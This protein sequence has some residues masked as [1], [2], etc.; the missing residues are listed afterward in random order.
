[1][2]THGQ[3][4]CCE[5]KFADLIEIK[6][7]I[8]PEMYCW[9]NAYHIS[10]SALLRNHESGFCGS[11]SQALCK[12]RVVFWN[13][14]LVMAILQWGSEGYVGKPQRAG[15]CLSSSWCKYRDPKVDLWFSIIFVFHARTYIK[16]TPYTLQRTC[17]KKFEVWVFHP[18]N[19][20][21]LM[22]DNYLLQNSFLQ[23]NIAGSYNT[24]II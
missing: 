18:H 6:V 15:Q 24:I 16:P 22:K 13:R 17:S 14:G 19:Q 9:F 12:P 8:L 5:I 10:L 3:A 7:T 4:N 11:L 21:Q 20:L 23:C 2:P 1:M